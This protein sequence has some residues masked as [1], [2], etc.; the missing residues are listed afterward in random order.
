MTKLVVYKAAEPKLEKVRIDN[1]PRRELV[2]LY[3]KPE[4]KTD[5]ISQV[6]RNVFSRINNE[7]HPSWGVFGNAKEFVAQVT[8]LVKQ[9]AWKTNKVVPYDIIDPA[10]KTTNTVNTY[11][12][13]IFEDED[14]ATMFRRAGHPLLES[15]PIAAAQPAALAPTEDIPA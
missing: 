13:F 2:T 5:R 8:G 14:E 12:M 6:V 9:G 10:T 3:Y 4:G 15:A 11:T 1:K 7:G